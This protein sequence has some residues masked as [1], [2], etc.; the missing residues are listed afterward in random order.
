MK[1][2]EYIQQQRHQRWNSNKPNK[3]LE[4]KPTLEK[5]KQGYRKKRK[6]VILFRLHISHTRT[7]RS[8]LLEAMQ[9][10]MCHSCMPDQIHCETHP[11]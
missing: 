1:I 11:Y 2:N 7:T 10:P 6:E 4:I 8:Y 5:W 9:Q 3:L